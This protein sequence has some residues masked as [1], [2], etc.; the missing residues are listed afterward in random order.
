M[1]I[2]AT[3]R[4]IQLENVDMLI[5]L[6]AAIKADMQTLKKMEVHK[7]KVLI[8]FYPSD[9]QIGNDIKPPREM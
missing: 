7:C 1:Q 2:T 9:P 4:K 8:A 6:K 5:K 3:Y